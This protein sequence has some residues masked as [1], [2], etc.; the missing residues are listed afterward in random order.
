MKLLLFA[1]FYFLH[2]LPRMRGLELSLDLSLPTSS[3]HHRA[4]CGVLTC[5]ER[6]TA[7]ESNTS[8]GRASSQRAISSLSIH[9][10]TEASLTDDTGYSEQEHLVA[11]LTLEQPEISRVSN[12]VKVD[13]VLEAGR[14]ELRLEMVKGI[15]CSAQY[16]CEVR[17][18][19]NK[20][21]ELVQTNR[22]RQ[23]PQERRG[24][25]T[26]RQS[27]A[28][29]ASSGLFQQLNLL[30]QQQ[31]TFMSSSLDSKFDA[32]ETRL[33][34]RL[35]TFDTKLEN[36][37]SRLDVVEHRLEDK[38]ETRVVDKLC[39]LEKKLSAAD[40][41]EQ[42][43]PQK[44]DEVIKGLDSYKEQIK[45]ENQKNQVENTLIMSNN[46]RKLETTM[47]SQMASIIS[48]QQK[49]QQRFN[50]LITANDGIINSSAHS[51]GPSNPSWL[52]GLNGANKTL[53]GLGVE[54]GT[55]QIAVNRPVNGAT[56]H[57]II[58]SR[59]SKIVISE[60]AFQNYIH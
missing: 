58:I 32:L 60:K 2:L 41:D 27:D 12:G 31:M 45:D 8:T 43:V 52:C 33:N 55:S 16:S 9:R 4:V 40:D 49:H 38:I 37:E 26:T 48:W 18:S 50:K 35:G 14:A 56:T 46:T 59:K 20:G 10:I 54:P 23:R 5:E 7:R 47:K 19:D 42:S 39:Q 30:Q 29:M 13:G 28:S 15:D 24:D 51:I 36:I 21:I 6:Y 3:R 22:L 57:Y 25:Q 53:H 17:T 1:S 44:L 34:G 11:T